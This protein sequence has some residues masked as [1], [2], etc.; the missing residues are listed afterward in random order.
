MRTRRYD[1]ADYYELYIPMTAACSA[2]RCLIIE[3]EMVAATL[4]TNP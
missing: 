4:R 2:A 1:D 3:P